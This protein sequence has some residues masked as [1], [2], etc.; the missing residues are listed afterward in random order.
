MQF[1]RS[2]VQSLPETF[3]FDHAPSSNNSGLNQQLVW[4]RVLNPVD[5]RNMQWYLPSPSDDTAA[6]ANTVSHA[7]AFTGWNPSG[8]SSSSHPPNQASHREAVMGQE[9]MNSIPSYARAS[10]RLE[11]RNFVPTNPLSLESFS[12]DLNNNQIANGPFIQNSSSDGTPQNAHHSAGF[13][14][15]ETG[16][17]PS[18]GGS[19]DPHATTSGTAEHPVEDRDGTPGSVDRRRLSCKR[20]AMEEAS[21]PSFAGTSNSEQGE[22]SIWHAVP[23]RQNTSGSLSV[24]SHVEHLSGVNAQDEHLNPRLEEVRVAPDSNPALNGDGS[25]ESSLRINPAHQVF[26]RPNLCRLENNIRRS[27]VRPPHPPSSGLNLSNQFPDSRQA[28]ANATSLQT[29][30]LASNF[31]GFMRNMHPFSWNG[32]P[33]SRAG[34]SSNSPLTLGQRSLGVREEAN[35]RSVPRSISDPMFMPATEMRHMTQDPINWSSTNGSASIPGNPSMP[36]NASFRAGSSSGSH[37]LPAPTWVPQQHPPHYPRRLSEVA[38]RTLFSS[39]G[40]D[41]G[42]SSGNYPP[43]RAAPSSSPEM[44]LPGA[45]HQGHQLSHLRSAFLM[46]RL[47]GDGALGVPS[48]LQALASGSEGRSRL[49]SEVRSVDS[50]MM[51]TSSASKPC[52]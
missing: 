32:A 18:A 40:S 13:V 43:A 26:A 50:D 17:I 19:S 33:N 25:V 4:N 1:P 20:K 9:L 34:S 39:A 28:A 23:G 24:S 31:P 44:V 35:V 30:S 3:E 16:Q 51:Y 29:Q 45:G 41:P 11:E 27:H 14:G 38:R 7:G 10:A 52:L 36:E 5:T 48:P 49:V 42:G 22:S 37:P 21:G 46:D 15:N 12:I 6:Y 8:P 47:V 2:T